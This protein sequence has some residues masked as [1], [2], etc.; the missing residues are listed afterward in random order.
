MALRELNADPGAAVRCDGGIITGCGDPAN[1]GRVLAMADGNGSPVASPRAFSMFFPVFE[2]KAVSRANYA[3]E[4]MR[5]KEV[6]ASAWEAHDRE[7]G[8]VIDQLAE[9][10]PSCEV[11]VIYQ[12]RPR[13]RPMDDGAKMERGV[14]VVSEVAVFAAECCLVVTDERKGWR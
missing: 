13:E 2:V 12:K 1:V 3:I 5:R 7:L 14:D 8:E 6:K 9:M 11:V 10:E 4:A